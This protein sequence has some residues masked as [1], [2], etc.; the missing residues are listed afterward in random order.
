MNDEESIKEKLIELE[1]LKKEEFDY[2]IQ[3][4]P[5]EHETNDLTQL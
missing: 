1:K 3:L 2:G 4:D 5:R